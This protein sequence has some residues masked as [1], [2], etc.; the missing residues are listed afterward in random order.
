[1]CAQSQPIVRSV[2]EKLAV[3]RE[4]VD[5]PPPNWFDLG[6]IIRIA[7][8][9]VLFFSNLSSTRMIF[10][11]IACFIYYVSATGILKY[12]CRKYILTNPPIVPPVAANPGSVANTAHN[13]V[14]YPIFLCI[15]RVRQS[16]L[17]ILYGTILRCGLEEDFQFPINRV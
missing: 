11:S 9:N 3:A 16:I 12:L 10:I 6:V 17:Q 1:M 5:I 2:Y 15:Y 4:V 13:A 7:L 8:A 14:S